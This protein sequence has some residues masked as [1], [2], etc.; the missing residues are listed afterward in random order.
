[1][2]A[3]DIDYESL[4]NSIEITGKYEVQII[5]SIT[6]STVDPELKREF[7]GGYDSDIESDYDSDIK[8]RHDSDN[9]SEHITPEWDT[10]I[11]R[12][13]GAG[14]SMDDYSNAELVYYLDMQGDIE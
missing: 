5:N 14:D 1:M 2:T 7:S 13:E 3:S 12:S 10:E 6:S 4:I 9:E 8:G 11:I